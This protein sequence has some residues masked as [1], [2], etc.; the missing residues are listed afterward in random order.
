MKIA[1]TGATGQLGRLVIDALLQRGA[2]PAQLVAIGRSEEKLEPLAGKGLQTRVADYNVEASLVAALEGV[3]KLLLVSSSE[4]GQRAT[5]HENVITAAQ[6]VNVKLIAYTSIANALTGNMKL[7]QEHIATE[8]LLAGSGIG[9]VLLR[10]GWY[11]ENYTDQLLG[12]LNS[13]V[14]LGA[15][16]DG[17]ISAATRADYAEAAA[18]VLL[19]E[20][21]EAG[22]IYELGG[23]K[24]FTLSQLAGAVGAAAGQDVAY[25]DM[26]PEKL[27]EIYTESGVPAVFADILVDTDLR[28]REGA[29]EVHSGDL[30]RLIGRA[31]TSLGKA[32]KDALAR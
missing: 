13:K 31:P 32:I 9:Y 11:T 7:A 26:D 18:A 21:G 12:Y 16:A 6:R 3:D 19:S 25:Q 27:G 29:L 8:H 17:K 23:D 10:N 28:I 2:D 20:A 5:Q 24:P 1:I 4:V 15:A 22:K 30:A 14:V